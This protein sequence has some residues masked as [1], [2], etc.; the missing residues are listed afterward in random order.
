MA[1]LYVVDIDNP[2]RRAAL[3]ALLSAETSVEFVEDEIARKAK[4]HPDTRLT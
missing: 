3:L 2:R 1:A 4:D